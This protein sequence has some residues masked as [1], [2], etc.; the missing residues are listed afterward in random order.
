ME[1]NPIP[2]S[3]NVHTIKSLA[4]LEPGFTEDALRWFIRSHQAD[5]EDLGIIW[6]S[7]TRVMIDRT[8]FIDYQKTHSRVARAVKG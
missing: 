1:A 2:V 7:G 6:Y 8:E 4:Q 5:L 3:G